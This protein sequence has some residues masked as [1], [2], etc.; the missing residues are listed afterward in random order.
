MERDVSAPQ[1]LVS[2]VL[3]S[4][5]RIPAWKIADPD[6]TSLALSAVKYNIPV[7]GSKQKKLHNS[8]S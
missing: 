8:F 6:P 5:L 1:T 4:G 3:G 7:S 2:S